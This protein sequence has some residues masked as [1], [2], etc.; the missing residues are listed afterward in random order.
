MR[1]V[2][3]KDSRLISM[4]TSSIRFVCVVIVGFGWLA[5]GCM[6][7]VAEEPSD[8]TRTQLENTVQAIKQKLQ[9]QKSVRIL[10]RLKESPP[11]LENQEG[12]LSPQHQKEAL[13]IRQKQ[14]V[15]EMKGEGILSGKPLKGSSFILMVITKEGLDRLLATQQVDTIQEDRPGKPFGLK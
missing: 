6:Y 5:L 1:S 8:T 9:H 10:V 2:L 14:F 12:L 3:K 4:M 13:L 11:G 7:S 15:N